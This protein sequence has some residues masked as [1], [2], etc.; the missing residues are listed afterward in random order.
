MINIVKDK[1]I[2]IIKNELIRK[3]L[4]ADFSYNI[5]KNEVTMKTHLDERKAKMLATKAIMCLRTGVFGNVKV[6]II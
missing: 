1:Y 5:D 4:I 6:K 2:Q 3:G